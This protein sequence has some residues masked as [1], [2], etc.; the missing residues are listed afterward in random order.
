MATSRNT[1]WLILA[2]VA[3][4]AMAGAPRH[5]A[6]AQGPSLLEQ[7]WP[8]DALAAWPRER[9][10]AR[11]T[12][13]H[14]APIPKIELDKLPAVAAS[15]IR[16]AVRR[17]ELPPGQKLVALTLDL[18]EQPGEIAGYDGP[19]FDYLRRNNVK[20]TIFAG[21]KWLMTHGERAEQLIAD[22]L[23][24]IGIHGWAHRNVRGLEGA[25]QRTEIGA[26]LLAFAVRRADL[27]RRQCAVEAPHLL[28]ALPSRPTLTRFPYGACNPQALETTA[29]LGLTAIQWDVSSGDATPT[30]P[31]STVAAHVLAHTKPGSIILAHANGRG[32]KTA[33]ALAIIVPKLKARG[34]SF[35]TVGEL[36]AAG[37]PVIVPTCYDARPGDTD[38]YDALFSGRR[39]QP[40]VDQKRTELV[41]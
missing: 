7:C 24:E 25:A 6:Q 33:E 2:V 40:A 19:I 21:G 10:P 16:G 18:C 11:G 38:R 30:L 1:H 14:N 34:F 17:V 4:L 27:S 9:T 28:A 36:M 39:P 3:A 22:P 26:P 13:G 5:P 41:P 35:V 37:R 12:P 32:F 23:L 8:A 20:A 15:Y 31:A 29:N